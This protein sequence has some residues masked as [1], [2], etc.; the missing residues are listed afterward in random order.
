[1]F[2]FKSA[3]ESQKKMKLFNEEVLETM[4]FFQTGSRQ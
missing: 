1:M 2:K 3:A 4:N